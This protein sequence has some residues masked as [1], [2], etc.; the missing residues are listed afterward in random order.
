M[1]SADCGLSEQAVPAVASVENTH[2]LIS[3][4]HKRF[5]MLAALIHIGVVHERL[6]DLIGNK[7]D[8]FTRSNDKRAC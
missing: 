4:K 2:M 7:S 5:S 6:A 1:V 8:Y 3:N